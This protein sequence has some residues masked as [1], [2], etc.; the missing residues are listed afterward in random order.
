MRDIALCFSDLE[1]R[2]PIWLTRDNYLVFGKQILFIYNKS[3][4]SNKLCWFHFVTI[5][6]PKVYTFLEVHKIGKT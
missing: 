3:F 2:Q 1:T 5:S 6:I 4:G